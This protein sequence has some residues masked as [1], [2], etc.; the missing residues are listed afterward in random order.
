MGTCLVRSGSQ[1]ICHSSCA[2]G[3]CWTPCWNGIYCL[4][5]LNLE[6]WVQSVQKARSLDPTS[7]SSEK[8]DY[9]GKQSIKYYFCQQWNLQTIVSNWAMKCLV[10]NAHSFSTEKYSHHQRFHLGRVTALSLITM[11][12]QCSGARCLL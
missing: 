5:W 6:A 4:K 1:Y 7:Y 2:W 10:D 3:C 8:I 11:G 12:G 9:N